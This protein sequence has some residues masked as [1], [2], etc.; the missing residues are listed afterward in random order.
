MAEKNDSTP[1]VAAKGT[2]KASGAPSGVIVYN[3]NLN[4]WR[5][6]NAAGRQVLVTGS[7]EAAQR[8]YPNFTV[9]EK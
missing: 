6:V 1:Q 7:K 8:A 5:C 2:A 4:A 3:P 9:K